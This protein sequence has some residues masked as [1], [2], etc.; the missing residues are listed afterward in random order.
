MK[1]LLVMCL[2]LAVV[3]T[4]DARDEKKPTRENAVGKNK[5]Q[6]AKAKKEPE[7]ITED[8]NPA[9]E[10]IDPSVDALQKNKGIYVDKRPDGFL[11]DPQ[12]LLGVGEREER[13]AFLNYHAGDSAIDLYVYL[14]EAD[15]VIPKDWHDDAW[16]D[17]TFFGARPAVVVF[18]HVG[19]PQRSEM[20]VTR[21]IAERVSISERH[22]A[23]ENV[24]MQA[25]RKADRAGQFEA[26]LIQMSNRIYWMERA[27]NGEK[28]DQSAAPALE[29][30]TKK[31]SES[32]GIEKWQPLL[33]KVTPYVAP[34]VSSL[35]LLLGTWLAC[36]LLRRRARYRLAE[37]E[38]EPR[39]GGPHAAGVGAVISFGRAAPSPTY[40]RE[41][42]PEYLR[43]A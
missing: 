6:K 30:P 2:A 23:M 10:P 3:S 28:S 1:I 20:R 19:K 24:M 41:Q 17:R 39:L 34:G 11:V 12:G 38:V 36:V 26:F 16:I 43:R 21:N 31:K 7:K 8:E 40:Q 22:R 13:A 27:I 37:F 33:D 35:V 32:K 9:H 14:F 5:S 18:Y 42:M 15:Q 29:Q 25:N 4:A